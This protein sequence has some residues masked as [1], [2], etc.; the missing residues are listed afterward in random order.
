M[1]LL[2][3]SLFR[4]RKPIL[5]QQ[6]FINCLQSRRSLNGIAWV[7][8]TIGFG[9]IPLSAFAQ[10][11]ITSLN[12]SYVQGSTTTLT[13]TVAS[14]SGSSGTIG[15]SNSST[16]LT[17]GSTTTNDLYIK[18]FGATV[19]G[20][21]KTFNFGGLTTNIY[22]RRKDNST[23]S[24]IRQLGFFERISGTSLKS[25]YAPDTE[26]ILRSQT[27]NRGTDNTFVNTGNSAGNNSNIERI[28]FVTPAGLKASTDPTQINDIGFLI[29]ERNGNDS[30]KI[31]AITGVDAF[32]TPTSFGPV[33]TQVASG[34]GKVGPN[35][36]YMVMRKDPSDAN[37][38][39]SDVGTQQITGIY[40]S[41][42]SLGVVAG[43]TIYGYSVIPADVT[44]TGAA[45]LDWMS[46]NYPTT[47]PDGGT[48]GLDLMAGGGVFTTHT[49]S[50]T[51]FQDLN[52]SKLQDNGELVTTLSGLNAV[53]L[54]ATGKVLQ[55]VPVLASNGTYKFTGVAATAIPGFS[56]APYKVMITTT[57]PTIGSTGVT[58][59]APAG[60]LYTGENRNGVIDSAVDGTQTVSVSGTHPITGQPDST[61]TPKVDFG[62]QKPPTAI[63][64]AVA[65]QSNPGG[66]TTVNIPPSSFNTST[67]DGTVEQYRITAFPNNVTS[68]TIGTT[69]YT[70][71]T[72]PAVGVTVLASDLNTIKIDPVDGTVTVEI[73]FKAI[74]NAGAESANT[75]TISVPFTNVVVSPPELI[76]LKRI[77]KINGSTVGKAANG[78]SIDLTQVVPQPDRTETIRNE[79]GD[80]TNPLDLAG[81]PTGIKWPTP[82]YPQGSTDA[83]VIKTGDLIEYTIYFLSIGGR[84]VTNANL[85]DWIPKNT[86]FE[87][88]TYGIGKGIQLAIGSIIHTLTNVPDSDRGE[89]FNPDAVLPATYPAGATSLL[90]CQTPLGQEGAVVVNLVKSTLPAP[91]NQLPNATATSTAA[92]SYGFIRFV[93]KVK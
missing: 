3:R 15:A 46:T 70:S 38:R 1:S 45:L 33:V 76:L 44:A 93:S 57:N 49:I 73:P 30:V 28:D 4:L 63:A 24:G 20:V 81:N 82:N 16:T 27:I 5:I 6:R 9:F 35:I 91:D 47:T 78:T 80:A 56:D 22:I 89:F 31:A 17:F 37:W 71:T 7:V 54:D 84:S 68:L 72:F 29:L 53:L 21:A 48:T 92:N 34:W 8:G 75:A 2:P 36:D 64:A 85:C 79:S 14:P 90:K 26:T 10:S 88:N 12:A 67:D 52:G 74:D 41:L 61:N 13:T 50:G 77:T 69:T 51:V 58:P 18:T 55:V 86:V 87:P 62:I 42:G 59:I 11:P 32:G 66:T 40:F 83:G 60:Y 25:S 43:Q 65:S 39:P 23:T 19:G